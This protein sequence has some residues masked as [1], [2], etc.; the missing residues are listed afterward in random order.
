MGLEHTPGARIIEPEV[1]ASYRL[2]EHSMFGS[3]ARHYD[4][5]PV[6]AF[7]D[8]VVI[9]EEQEGSC[10]FSPRTTGPEICDDCIAI[11]LEFWLDR[12]P[13]VVL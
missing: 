10:C 3:W 2:H 13:T 6:G 11:A 9:A 8:L 4:A 1:M 7:N 12:V 5:D